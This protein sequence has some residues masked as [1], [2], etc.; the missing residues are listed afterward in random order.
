LP[1]LRFTVTARLASLIRP[2]RPALNATLTHISQTFRLAL[3]APPV[4][5]TALSAPRTVLEEPSASTVLWGTMLLMIIPAEC[6]TTQS[7]TAMTATK[8]DSE[9]RFVFLAISF[10]TQPTVQRAFLAVNQLQNAMIVINS[11]T[12]TASTVLFAFLA[13]SL[14]LLLT[15]NF[16]TKASQS[17]RPA[18]L[19]TTEVR[20]VSSA[21]SN[22]TLS[23]EQSAVP[24][25]LLIQIAST[26]T[27]SVSAPSVC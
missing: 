4:F 18:L 16:V 13:T 6:A 15:A 3:S 25:F 2:L 27:I 21:T 22:T 12:V 7:L 5:P 14:I 10:I 17:A 19:F 26:A 24:V 20:L 1:A 8:L 11:I 9:A 23:T